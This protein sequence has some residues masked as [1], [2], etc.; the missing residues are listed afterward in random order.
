[1]TDTSA[2][3]PEGAP[4][5]KTADPRPGR[6]RSP[7]RLAREFSLKGLYQ[8]L[9]NQTHVQDLIKGF[10]EEEPKDW[11][12]A[13]PELC[14]SILE[15]S[16]GQLQ[17]LQTQLE[18]HL[19]RPINELSPIERAVLIMACFELNAHPEVP[20]RVVINEAIELTKTY[21]GTDG[22]RFVNGVLDKLAER[23][24]PH[25]RRGT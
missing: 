14:L 15:G 21:G 19:D 2:F 20:Y 10:Q 25:E 9:L 12:R 5:V 8:H 18:P 16:L 7:R 4:P 6:A 24:R 11:A 1:V 23:Q 13:D 17:T 3:T 22:H